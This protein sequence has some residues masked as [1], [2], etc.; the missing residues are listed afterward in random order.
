VYRRLLVRRVL[1]LLLPTEDFENGCLRS[2]LGEILAEMLLGRIIVGRACE[3]PFL[4][5]CV[6]KAVES[7][8]HRRRRQHHQ[9]R[10]PTAP[11]AAAAAAESSS[12][13][14]EAAA[15]DEATPDKQPI[16]SLAE[17]QNGRRLPLTSP[18]PPPP[19]VVPDIVVLIFGYACVVYSVLRYLAVAVYTLPSLPPR[20]PSPPHPA[21]LTTRRSSSNGNNGSAI[22]ANTRQQQQ[23][24]QPAERHARQ[25]KRAQKRPVLAL[26]VWPCISSVLGL[27]SR[28]PW[29]EGVFKLAQY[30]LIEGP[31]RVGDTDGPLDR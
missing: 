6:V 17:A 21:V 29:L 2:L 25:V 9:Q 19:P 20:T 14:S 13:A 30:G 24:P 23:Q 15:P 7:H 4:M 3:G 8:H 12:S 26:R 31:G 10:K 16:P 22:S 28:M 1:E 11:V 5:R 18:A 27:S